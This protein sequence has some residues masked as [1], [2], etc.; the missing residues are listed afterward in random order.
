MVPVETAAEETLRRPRTENDSPTSLEAGLVTALGGYDNS[1]ESKVTR[2][3][4]IFS[5]TGGN[6]CDFG[7]PKS[8]DWS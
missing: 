5:E 7:S 6:V 8:S 2:L 3:R 4:T 1:R